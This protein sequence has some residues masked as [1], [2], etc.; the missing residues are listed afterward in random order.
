MTEAE[1]LKGAMNRVENAVKASPDADFWAGIEGGLEER[2][3]DMDCFA[4]I[5][6]TSRSGKSGKGRTGTFFLPQKM[7]D[8]VKS[9]MELG[10]ADDVIFNQKNSKQ[11]QGT[12]GTLTRNIVDRT[13]FYKDAVVFALIPFM[14][15]ELY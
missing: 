14:N 2:N 4:W 12:V 10:D 8:L 9:G 13:E 3:G 1:T 11:K 6:I 5:Y 7:A 15:P